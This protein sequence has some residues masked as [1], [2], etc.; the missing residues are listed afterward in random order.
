MFPAIV[1]LPP[2]DRGALDATHARLHEVDLAF[3]V[4]ANAAEYGAPPAGRW[5][6]TLTA[7]APGP[8]TAEA[9]LACGIAQVRIPATTQDSEGLLALPE[10]QDVRGKRVLIFRGD[11]G[12][13]LLADTLRTRGAEVRTVTCYRR[14]APS[15]GAAGLVEALRDRRAHAI[16]VTSSEGLDNLWRALGDDGRSLAHA[17]PWFAP[18]ARIASHGR[19][20]GLT[21][22][23]T[24]PGDAGLIAGL[25]A[26]SASALS[27]P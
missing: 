17:L 14:A 24:A 16:T 12:R 27:A 25:L 10:L 11:G 5:P 19:A 6:A 2:E 3:F 18:H 4:S 1:I 15:S 23:E 22:I 8:G 26:W 9:L 20:V 7:F 21:M 13:E